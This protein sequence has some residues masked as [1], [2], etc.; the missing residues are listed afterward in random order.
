MAG[1]KNFSKIKVSEVFTVDG[2]HFVKIDSL[3]YRSIENAP[4]GEQMM[5]AAFDAKIN[6][7]TVTEVKNDIDCSAK[8]L[9]AEGNRVA[10][11]SARQLATGVT[12]PPYKSKSEEKRVETLKKARASKKTKAPK[13]AAK[14]Q[15]KRKR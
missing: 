8:I 10:P 3:W 1:F 7:K 2:E 6:S 12:K 4:L 15:A 13:K 9:D 14:K 11:P 5:T